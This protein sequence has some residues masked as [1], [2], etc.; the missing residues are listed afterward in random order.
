MIVLA[1]RWYRWNNAILVFNRTDN[2]KDCCDVND[3]ENKC[4]YETVAGLPGG[5]SGRQ[6]VGALNGVVQAQLAM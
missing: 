4:A 2:K 3:E 6:R 1:D 5:C